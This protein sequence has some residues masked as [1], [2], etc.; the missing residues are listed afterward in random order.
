ME[1]KNT[2]SFSFFTLMKT[3]KN[4]LLKKVKLNFMVIFQKFGL[5][6]I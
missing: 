1:E 3:L 5:H 2:V 4:E 6:V